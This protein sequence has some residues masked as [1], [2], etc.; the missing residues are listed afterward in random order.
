MKRTIAACCLL[1]FSALPAAVAATAYGGIEI[2]AKG[3]KARLFTFKGIG[4]NRTVQEFYSKSLNTSLVSSMTSGKFTEAGI[5]EVAKAVQRHTEDMKQTAGREKLGTPE[6]FVIASSSISK[7]I[8][9]QELL[10]AV[11]QSSGLDITLIDS[12]TENMSAFVSTVPEPRRD[13]ALLID[14]GSGNAT[15]GCMVDGDLKYAE[16]PYGS[17][18]LRNTSIDSSD[19]ESALKGVIDSMIKPA[20]RKEALNKPCLGNRGRIYW[21]GGAAWAAA[22]FTHPERATN[23]YVAMSK[24]DLDTFLGKLKDGTWNANPPSLSFPKDTP[25]AVRSAATDAALRDW[26]GVQNVFARED[27][28]AG[29]S[30]FRALLDLSNPNAKILFARN[31]NLLYGYALSA[32]V[33]GKALKQV[34]KNEAPA[35]P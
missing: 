3:V 9:K 1:L 23:A 34:S 32:F 30:L 18:S 31:G 14:T 24:K 27:L 35:R 4:D 11:R 5:Q 26:K 15:A 20:Y 19:Y 13:E 25:D 12:K 7:A 21:I 22:T 16:I 17:V 29:V 2:G 6:F 8:N 28:I 10:A 33:E